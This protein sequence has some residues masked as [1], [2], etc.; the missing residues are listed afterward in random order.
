MLEALKDKTLKKRTLKAHKKAKKATIKF[1]KNF[2]EVKKIYKSDANF[3]L[4]KLNCTASQFQDKL[5][6]YNI[7]I[8]DCQNF[9]FLNEYYIRVAIKKHNAF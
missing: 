7:Y 5:A 2:S 9:D 3:L 6:K 8:R 1:F 4:I